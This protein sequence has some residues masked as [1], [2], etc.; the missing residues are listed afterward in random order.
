MSWLA[1]RQL[2]GYI[3]VAADWSFVVR[4]LV[5]LALAFLQNTVLQAQQAPS[6]PPPSPIAVRAARLIDGTGAPAIQDAVVVV[7][8]NTISAVGRWG[9]VSIP[10][11]ATVVDLG[12]A[13]LLPGFIDAHVHLIGRTLGDPR[14]DD[15]PVR[16]FNA[17]GAILGVPNAEQTLLAGFT[18]VRNVGAPDF[19]DMA[20]RQAINEGRIPGPRMQA[21]GQPL[22]ITGGH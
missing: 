22:G 17:M 16:D 14:H 13:T 18:S 15:A 9:A 12:D 20:L 7:S 1:A 11:G 21:A 5:L 3:S 6:P 19:Q 10:A 2:K 4:Y 8:G